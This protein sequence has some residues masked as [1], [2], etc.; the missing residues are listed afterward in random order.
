VGTFS[1]LRRRDNATVTFGSDSFLHTEK[2]AIV[3]SVQYG[4][5]PSEL[6]GILFFNPQVVS[7]TTFAKVIQTE[8]ARKVIQIRVNKK[9]RK[10]LWLRLLR[11][12]E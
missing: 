5:V 2:F 7:P 11:N 9:S 3:S 8:F 1:S 10:P 6:Q 12:G 4:F